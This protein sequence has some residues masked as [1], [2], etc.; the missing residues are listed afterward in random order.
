VLNDRILADSPAS[1][2][3]SNAGFASRRAGQL[4]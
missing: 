3:H 1:R 2:N 4:G